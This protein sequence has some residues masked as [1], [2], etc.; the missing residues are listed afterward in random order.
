MK[1]FLKVT[2]ASVA[3]LA[4]GAAGAQEVRVGSVAGV[5]GPIADLIA[6]IVEGRNLAVR[7]VNEQGGFFRSGDRMAMVLGDSA[8][9]PKAA[10]DASTKV[11]NVDRVVAIVG[12]SCSGATSAM[13]QSVTAPAGV[14]SVSESATAPSISRL[15]DND[16]A[17]RTAASDAYQGRALARL[18]RDRGF[19]TVSVTAA[20]DDYNA[21]LG[22]VFSEA[23]VAMGGNLAASAL[24][25]P[26]KASYRSE[27]ASLR[28]SGTQALV[29]FAYYGSSGI[30]IM[31]NALETRMFNTFFGADGMADQTVIDQLGAENLTRTFFTTPSADDST[32]AYKRFAEAA[33]AANLAPGAPFV[34][35]GYDATFVLALA[36]EKA[37]STDRAAIREALR[38]V[39]NAP[40]EPILPGEWEKAKALIAEGTDIDY[41]GASGQIDFDE[42]GD[43]AG[44]YSV[45]SVGPDGT[46]VS[47]LLK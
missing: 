26:N 39:A 12:A 35:Q 23:F 20:N 11:V 36:I 42:N 44:V 6:P 9:D 5:T 4:A 28:K 34:A 19:R 47:E 10:V 37:G 13:V 16:L 2:A 25:E 14:V 1:A 18:V 31:R 22:K 40:G 8:C 45:N 17:F 24:H 46:W 27:V 21:A 3:L 33:A 30:T 7:H 43:V 15:D 32:D 29:V 41:V 38:E